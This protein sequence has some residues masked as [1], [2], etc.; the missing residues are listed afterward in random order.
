MDGTGEFPSNVVDVGGAG[1]EVGGRGQSSGEE[2][3]VCY[4]SSGVDVR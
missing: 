2:M 4:G 3:R 1:R